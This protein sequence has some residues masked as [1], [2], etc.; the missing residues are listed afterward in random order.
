MKEAILIL[1]PENGF[2]APPAFGVNL[3]D[4]DFQ[5]SHPALPGE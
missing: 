4:P 5:A 1:N 3:A 2:P